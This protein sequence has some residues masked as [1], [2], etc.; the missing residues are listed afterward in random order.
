MRPNH[1]VHY[2]LTALFLL[3]NFCSYATEADKDDGKGD[4]KF[5]YSSYYGKYFARPEPMLPFNDTPYLG[6]EL[7][8]GYQTNGQQYWQ[9]ALNYPYYGFGL[10]TGK[11][12]KNYQG[13]L[14]GGF[15]FIDIPVL[16]FDRSSLVTS[17]AMGTT[18]NCNKYDIPDHP[19]FMQG[20]SYANV[21]SHV[22]L[23]YMYKLNPHFNVGAG[24]RFQHF[25]NDG[26]QYPNN[27]L[28]MVSAEIKVEYTP[29]ISPKKKVSK[30]LP[31][32]KKHFTLCYVA[33]ICGEN[34]NLDKKY[35]NTSISI[36]YNAI[37]NPCYA[38]SFGLDGTYNGYVNLEQTPVGMSPHDVYT[39]GIFISNEMITGK[40]SFGIQIGAHMYNRKSIISPIYERLFIRYKVKSRSFVHFGIRAN[41]FNSQFLEWGFGYRL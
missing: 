40:I 10:Y 28:E 26:W 9:Q 8:L 27:G 38:L 4:M 37:E 24:I 36:A 3:I 11:Y 16:V 5:S 7:K 14:F 35:F 18:L 33:G 30:P 1:L 21:Y 22:T 41:E 39:S 34:V 20:S 17:L 15:I 13:S 2:V 25:S 23:N 19:T 31:I 6:H 12:L 32:D 29:K